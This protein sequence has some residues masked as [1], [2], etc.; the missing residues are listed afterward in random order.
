MK[1]AF[2]TDSN[3]IM[4]A[5]VTITSFLQ[6]NKGR[7]IELYLLYL[8]GDLIE[9]DLEALQHLVE[10][11][12][13]CFYPLAIDK[14]KLQEMPV[15]RHG[16]S[17][18]LRIF[19]PQLLPD[20]DK[21]LY[22]DVDI[23]VETSLQDLYDTDLTGY[24]FAAVPDLETLVPDYLE[25]IGFKR[26]GLYFCAGILL[27]N[28]KELRKMDLPSA[29]KSYLMQYKEKI[30]HSDQDILNCICTHVKYLPPKYNSIK[31]YIKPIC[32]KL[33]DKKEIR[34]A[35]QHPSIIHYLGAAKPWAYLTI[36]PH[37]NRW[38][39]YLQMTPFKN[40][41]PSDRNFNNFCRLQILKGKYL[42]VKGRILLGEM[43]RMIIPS[44]FLQR[45]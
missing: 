8:K 27:M 29:T 38:Y 42:F 24:Q 11:Y 15:L 23:V 45:N 22:L 14:E 13:V 33:W 40:Y 37:K 28:L 31:D 20:V 21:I 43:K 34:E 1:I 19:L 6:N 18:Y 36:H 10:S 39:K 17:T 30:G 25:R 32:Q 3:Y 4:P 5:T 12:Q 2:S 35:R 16:L 9:K 26:E 7:S 41:V 44:P